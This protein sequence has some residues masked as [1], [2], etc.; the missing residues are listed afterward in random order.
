MSKVVSEQIR[1]I[2]NEKRLT[3]KELSTASGLSVSKLSKLETGKARLSVETAMVLANVLQVPVAALLSK[4][5]A[6]SRARR[7]I[8]RAGAG[9]RHRQP[10]MEFEVL[11]SDLK[12]KRNVFWRVTITAKTIEEGGGW[13]KHP[14]EE[15]LHILSGTLELHTEHYEPLRLS[16]GDSI[17]FDADVPH[18]Y[19]VVEGGQVIL[20]MSNT[21]PANG[22]DI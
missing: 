15:F 5:T 9:L 12:E 18:A 1:I 16:P 20:M 11:C 22:M 3:L 6:E 21:V 14:G 17:L 2:R 13:R 10:G 4:P 8:T 7:S 19:V